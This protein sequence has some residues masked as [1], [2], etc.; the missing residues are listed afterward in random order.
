MSLFVQ[1]L[2]DAIAIAIVIYAFSLSVAKLIAKRHH[3]VIHSGQELFAYALCNIIS[4]FFLCHPSAGSL[5]RTIISSTVGSKSQISSVFASSIVLL[6]ILWV[7]NLLESLPKLIWIVAFTATVSWDVI[8]GLSVAV[9]FAIMTILFRLQWPKFIELA[10]IKEMD[11]YVEYKYYNLSISEDKIL[12]FCYESPLLFF[13]QE[14]F[15]CKF[16]DFYN[17][18]QS[19]KHSIGFV[20][21][22][23]SSISLIDT[24]GTAAISEILQFLKEKNIQFLI[25]CCKVAIR[26][27]LKTQGIPPEIF[28]PTLHDAFLYAHYQILKENEYVTESQISFV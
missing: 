18:S 13:N 4:S 5:T 21:F 22:D 15:K 7:A 6:V 14:N 10:P 8:E 20:I 11:I 23:A 16:Y 28:F 3:Y 25:S 9:I 19:Y 17:V 1:V 26:N 2:P 24:A 12:A 27:S